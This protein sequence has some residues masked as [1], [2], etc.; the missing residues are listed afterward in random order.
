MVARHPL[1]VLLEA[2]HEQLRGKQ[3]KLF[4]APPPAKTLGGLELL[5][6]PQDPPAYV[7]TGP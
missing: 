2:K 4:P 7:G 6:I 5:V 1:Y 3:Q